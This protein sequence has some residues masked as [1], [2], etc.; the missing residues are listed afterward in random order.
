MFRAWI[1]LFTS[2]KGHLATLHT[3]IYCILDLHRHNHSTVLLMCGSICQ[4]AERKPVQTLPGRWQLFSKP[5]MSIW[6]G[7]EGA[8]H[9][10][11]YSSKNPTGMFI[12]CSMWHAL[13][14][15]NFPTW[16]EGPGWHKKAKKPNLTRFWTSCYLNG[17]K[18]RDF[19]H[20]TLKYSFL[21]L[22]AMLRTCKTTQV[23]LLLQSRGGGGIPHFFP[24]V[25]VPCK[26]LLDT[27]HQI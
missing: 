24:K 4:A 27:R 9:S 19:R 17:Y 15:V 25:S 16:L 20:A 6:F 1:L 21:S 13:T 11:S 23:C 2:K 22:S 8:S 18:Y 26:I 12:P 3:C 14:G 10:S 7:T 5:A